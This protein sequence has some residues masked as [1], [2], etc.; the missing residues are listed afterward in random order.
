MEFIVWWQGTHMEKLLDLENLKSEAGKVWVLKR[1]TESQKGKNQ[2]RSPQ[3]VSVYTSEW[4]LNRMWETDSEQLS[5]WPKFWTQTRL[6]T[7][8]CRNINNCKKTGRECAFI[9]GWKI[10]H[11]PSLRSFSLR[12]ISVLGIHSR[13]GTYGERCSLPGL[14]N[15]KKKLRIHELWK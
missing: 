13:D 12:P 5:Q 11:F 15:Q 14:K 8:R 9:G 4:C 2:K 10:A 1:V 6:A 7:K 3:I